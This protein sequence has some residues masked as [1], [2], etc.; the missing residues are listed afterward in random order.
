VGLPE[1]A[2]SA[3]AHLQVAR[4]QATRVVGCIFVYIKPGEKLDMDR[5]DAGRFVVE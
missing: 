4:Q 1:G 2:H 3:A 5:Q